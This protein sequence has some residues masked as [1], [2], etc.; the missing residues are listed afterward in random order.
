MKWVDWH[1]QDRLIILSAWLSS[2][3]AW[4]LCSG[5]PRWECPRY[6][7]IF[8]SC[9]S[10]GFHPCTSFP[11]FLVTSLLVLTIQVSW[12]ASDSITHNSLVSVDLW[13]TQPGWPKRI[14]WEAFPSPLSFRT[15]P[16][17]DLLQWLCTSYSKHV[18]WIYV[19]IGIHM[20][21][22]YIHISIHLFVLFFRRTLIHSPKFPCVPW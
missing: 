13:S 21:W 2:T 8:T 9:S 22:I 11:D 4:G 1:L 20:W 10:W 6:L 15:I 14:Y 17:S 7:G 19:H 18:I 16:E 12:P 3:S 5:C